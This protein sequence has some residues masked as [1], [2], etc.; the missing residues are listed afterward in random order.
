MLG[1][2]F[3][4]NT[5]SLLVLGGFVLLARAAD[6]PEK[7]GPR[8][9][10]LAGGLAGAAFGLKLTCAFS[11]FALLAS[12]LFIAV[13]QRRLAPALAFGSGSAAGLALTT[14]YWSLRLWRKFGDPFFPFG[15]ALFA[16]PFTVPTAGLDPRFASAG[17]ADI[18]AVPVQLAIG[19]TNRLQEVPARDVRH[20]LLLVLTLAAAL[21]WWFRPGRAREAS[22]A[23]GGVVI[24]GWLALF[25]AWTLSLHYYR[26]F[27]A[28]EFLAPV[29]LLALLRI[30][31]A[32]RALPAAWL[33]TAALVV[34][35]T[36]TGSWGRGG[37]TPGPL[38]VRVP[39]R[40]EGTAPIV[41]VDGYG[42]SFAFPFFP[43]GTRF[44]GLTGTGSAFRELVAREVARGEGPL[45]RV[46]LRALPA[47]PLDALGLRDA[48]PCEDFRTGG[49]G[50]LVLCR[51]E[52]V[53][54]P[55]EAVPE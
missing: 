23:A 55:R 30:V 34:A 38:D 37:W 49:R 20:L 7:E 29:A 51:L 43:A 2:T 14:G 32:R 25:G 54:S 48:P 9:V 1:T 47:T 28:G 44:F 36:A 5:L 4:D 22:T 53:G 26:Y 12:A 27:A 13:R 15:Q 40:A 42:V 21:V 18:L 46:R 6:E 50:R 10:A 39:M 41:L 33:A 8:R 17:M 3:G 16:S 52:R 24:A 31:V 11:A 45:Y 19:Q 35:T